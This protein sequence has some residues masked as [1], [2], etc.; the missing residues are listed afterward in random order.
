MTLKKYSYFDSINAKKKTILEAFSGIEEFTSC[1]ICVKWGKNEIGNGNLRKIGQ[2]FGI[3]E[4]L[5]KCWLYSWGRGKLFQPRTVDIY[6]E[7]FLIGWGYKECVFFSLFP[8]VFFLPDVTFVLNIR[9]EFF[10][11]V[12]VCLLLLITF[13][14][15]CLIYKRSIYFGRDVSMHYFFVG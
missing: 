9:N 10:Y 7:Y 8:S 1:D 6:A 13:F 2:M 14:F 11:W 4:T 12:S 5:W 3:M 15:W